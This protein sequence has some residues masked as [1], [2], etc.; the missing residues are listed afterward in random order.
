MQGFMHNPFA[1][2]RK[3]SD[4]EIVAGIQAHDPKAEEC[5]FKMLSDYFDRHF[6]ELFFDRDSREE[7]FQT[8]IIKIW[9]EIENK[10]IKVIDNIICRRQRDGGYRRM[11]CSLTTFGMAFAKN[12]FRELLRNYKEDNFEDNFAGTF[13]DVAIDEEDD[14]E[15][16]IQVVDECIQSMSPNCRDILTLFYYKHMSL[17]EI[18]AARNEKNSS[19]DGLKTAKNKCMTT[20]RQRVNQKLKVG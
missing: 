15:F 20:L 2:R 18:M 16:R 12:D 17:D 13:P 6:N 19:K 5:F 8:S 14:E 10:T 1:R 4:L 11:T 3:M 9:T 7:I